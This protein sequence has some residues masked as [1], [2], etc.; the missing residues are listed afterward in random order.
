MANFLIS[1]KDIYSADDANGNPLVGGQLFTYIAGSNTPAATYTDATGTVENLNPIILDSRG[2]AH[3]WLSDELVYKYVLTKS[4]ADGG[5]EIRTTDNIQAN[6]GGG[7]GG[8]LSFV[9]H[10]DST[11]ISIEGLGTLPSPLSATAIISSI[12]TNA[13]EV[14]TSGEIPAI[15]VDSLVG[16]GV[17]SGLELGNINSVP[18]YLVANTSVIVGS[19]TSTKILFNFS[20]VQTGIFYL[21]GYLSGNKFSVFSNNAIRQESWDV[22]TPLTVGQKYDLQFSYSTVNGVKMSINDVDQALNEVLIGVALAQP[23]TLELLI[24]INAAGAQVSDDEIYETYWSDNVLAINRETVIQYAI[25][26]EHYTQQSP[27]API[28]DWIGGAVQGEVIIIPAIPYTGGMNV[29]N[30]S[31]AIA[32]KLD[33]VDATAQNVNSAVNWVNP[34]TYEGTQH[35]QDISYFADTTDANTNEGFIYGHTTKGLVLQGDTVEGAG[36]ITLL[37]ETDID[38]TLNVQAALNVGGLAEFDAPATFNEVSTHLKGVDITGG[39]TAGL[40]IKLPSNAY[41]GNGANPGV[42]TRLTFDANFHAEDSNG[43]LINSSTN[44]WNYK[45]NGGL[46][47]FQ[48][49]TGNYSLTSGPT[50]TTFNSL[51]YK[52]E[53]VPD[54]TIDKTYGQNS[55]GDLVKG[56]ATGD[57]SIWNNSVAVA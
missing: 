48:D 2:E 10:I 19:S 57:T 30:L 49:G 14:I 47:R 20:G 13:L 18:D 27:D 32:D 8:D 22:V 9:A 7:G 35:Q 21:V 41:I 43:N 42:G 55:A 28:G 36:K 23:T 11:T 16:D 44:D 15:T 38:S 6:N 31:D 45:S 51:N 33:K 12:P 1:P 46:H 50:T 56:D 4:V 17:D 34:Q 5:A 37:N 39:L 54:G 53:T 26:E 29:L 24:G 25:G 52:F 3:V 40:H